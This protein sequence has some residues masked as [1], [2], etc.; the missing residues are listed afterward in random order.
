MIKKIH[1]EKYTILQSIRKL[2]LSKK[3]T[4]S[5]DN[6]NHVFVTGTPTIIELPNYE[7]LINLR[8]IN[9]KLN[10]KGF[11]VGIND[12]KNNNVKNLNSRFKVNSLFYPISN[13][14]FLN[15]ELTYKPHMVGL[16]DIRI[17]YF[18]EK[19]YYNS[20]I[21]DTNRLL[22]VTSSQLYPID[23]TNYELKRTIIVPSHYD[24]EQ[25]KIP[26]KNWSFVKYNNE[27]CIVYSWFPLKIGKIDYTTNQL[28]IIECNKMPEYFKNTRGSTPGY[29]KNNEIWFVV[30]NAIEKEYLHFFVVFD[31]QMKLL[32]YSELFKFNNC[33][34]EFC[35]SLIVH[36]THLIL[37]YSLMDSQSFIGFYDIQYIKQLK[38]Y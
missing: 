10:E 2:N 15:E 23:D 17:F 22:H 14:F 33:K 5:I 12:V 34:V 27:L 6:E 24:I 28:T 26:E 9:Y 19:Y 31:L 8:W 25:I 38:W 13:E 35:I 3:I 7:Y 16:E 11:I 36:D 4:K 21:M 30:H 1:K 37:S 29:T 20:T 32:R 18:D